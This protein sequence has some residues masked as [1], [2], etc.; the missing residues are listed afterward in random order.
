MSKIIDTARCV[1]VQFSAV[2]F[3]ATET[4]KEGVALELSLLDK[5]GVLI[6]KATMPMQVKAKLVE[7]G[8][9]PKVVTDG[10]VK[11]PFN[12]TWEVRGLVIQEGDSAKSV[13]RVYG[14]FDIVGASSVD[15]M[16]RK[17]IV[18]FNPF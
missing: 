11:I 18:E 9:A 2:K 13:L 7:A 3:L 15:V 14:D 17:D 4:R 6:C 5:N 8:M 12:G 16:V 10:T 1:A